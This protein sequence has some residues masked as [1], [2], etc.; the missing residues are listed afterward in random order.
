MSSN[1]KS[2]GH[3]LKVSVAR[4]YEALSRKAASLI[5]SELEKKRDLLL[6]ASAG[7][8]PSGL[9]RLLGKESRR[10]PE[11]FSALRVIQIDEWLGVAP[12]HPASC[13][14]DLQVKLLAPAGIKPGRFFGFN[15]AHSEPAAECQ[16]MSRLLQREGPVDICILGLGRN[17]HVAMNE[18]AEFITSGVHIAT[19]TSGSQK[20][21]LLRAITPKPKRGL[22][23]G[24]GDILRSR[25]VLLLVNGAHK[26]ACLSRLL[27]GRVTSRFPASL[28]WLHQDAM[29]L[30]DSEAVGAKKLR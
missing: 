4:D 17:G 12:E 11:L 21:P 20:H 28:L 16:R 8:T 23:L 30:C 5:I 13:R 25:K 24:I 15:G 2:A 29:V 22:T 18:P 9:Y 6:C 26:R 14:N 27:H 1:T 7:G 19:L 3:G 10:R